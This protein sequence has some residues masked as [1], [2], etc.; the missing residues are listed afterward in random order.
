MSLEGE[1]YSASTNSQP[2][3]GHPRFF[4]MTMDE[5]DLHARKNHDYACGGDPLGNF[6]RVGKFLEMYPGLRLNDPAIVAITYMLKQL[7]AYLWIKSNKHETRSE[8]I[9]DRLRDIHVY[10]KLVRIIEEEQAK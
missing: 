6:R 7:D 1:I 2:R 10:T 5:A 9:Q 3:S 8:G 4:E